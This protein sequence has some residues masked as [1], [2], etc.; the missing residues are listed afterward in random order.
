MCFL[1]C[2]SCAPEKEIPARIDLS[3]AGDVSEGQKADSSLKFGVSC[4]LS[5]PETYR[6]YKALVS[7]LSGRTGEK[8]KFVQRHNCDDFI[9]L[10][11]NDAM[12]LARTGV[13][14]YLELGKDS[15]VR[16]LAAEA[17]AG[18]HHYRSLIIVP[19]DSP[20]AEFRELRGKS[21]V[22]SDGHS[23]TGHHWAAYLI[24]LA[25][26]DE[27]NFFSRVLWSGNHNRSIRFV[28][29]DEADGACVSSRVLEDSPLRSKVKVIGESPLFFAPPLMAGKSL[30]PDLRDTIKESL[31]N[32]HRDDVGKKALR[33]LELSG[34]VPASEDDYAFARKIAEAVK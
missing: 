17:R 12:S 23:L 33:E 3:D 29:D 20:I 14:A 4:C 32:M 8:I 27:K 24:K 9:A 34:F 21:F 26:F 28:V 30:D 19:S 11:K 10:L 2:S 13:G 22:F 5:C 15:G 1:V 18:S 25:G 16:I 7:Y 6:R 31:L